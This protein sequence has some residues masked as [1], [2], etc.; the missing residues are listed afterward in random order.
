[1]GYREAY[2]LSRLKMEA[3]RPELLHVSTADGLRSNKA[4]FVRADRQGRLWYG[5]DHGVDVLA[6]KR[7]H[8][9]G[10]GDGLIWDDVNSNAFFSDSR[11]AVWIGTSRGLS[12]FLPQ[13]ESWNAS[14]PPP[15]VIR[16]AMLGERAIGT[17]PAAS[18]PYTNNSLDVA[19]AGLTFTHENE[20]TFRYRLLGIESDFVETAHS[21]QRYAGTPSGRLH[22]RSSG[23]ERGGHMERGAG[24][25]RIFDQASVVVRVV[26]SRAVPRD[27]DS[28]GAR[29][30][31]APHDEAARRA[32]AARI[33]R[34]RAHER[35]D[36][37]KIA[38]ARRKD[39]GRKR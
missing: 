19:F 29:F 27:F 21:E 23:A 37:G 5:S 35:A 18:A 7:W 1:M 38:R 2:G 3:G 31:A 36:S 17:G 32:G 22:V 11:G 25:A 13:P 30:V 9:Y 14:L 34:T 8:H 33:R 26:V 4:I 16:S 39:A 6:G 12:Q 15:V 24:A 10:R 20:V 28:A